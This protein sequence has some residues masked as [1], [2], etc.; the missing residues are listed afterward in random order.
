M[1]QFVIERKMP[2]VGNLSAADLQQASRTSCDT[3]RELGPEI[4]WVQSY[5]T[6]NK[7]YCVYRAPDEGM[8]R[9]H[10]QKTGFPADSISQVRSVIDPTT[11]D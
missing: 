4:Q 6:D 8:I 9:E 7:I 3:L 11:A 2:N 10:A 5:V 1:P